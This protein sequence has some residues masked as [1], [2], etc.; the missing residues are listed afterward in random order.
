[1]RNTV[2]AGTVALI[3]GVVLTSATPGQAAGQTFAY[4]SL[5]NS[6]YGESGDFCLDP[7]AFFTSLELGVSGGLLG[8]SAQYING[9]WPWPNR[10]PPGSGALVRG[11]RFSGAGGVQES[12]L[13]RHGRAFQFMAQFNPARV[14]S[15]GVN[16]FV[17]PFV[18]VG[19]HISTDGDPAAAA[20]GQP[21]VYGIK[22]QTRP[23]VAYG[24]NGLLPLGARV[25][26]TAGYRG[27]SVFFGDFQYVTPQGTAVEPS[28]G[29]T[30]TSGIWTVGATIR[31]GS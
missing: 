31:V 26:L 28:P 20:N 29:Q 13:L 3:T 4:A 18:G 10:P 25:G 19:V 2:I 8:G 24:V 9:D 30:L 12:V 6:A 16:R 11:V 22:G 14:V 17:R 5:G 23:F 21:V 27:T 7:G 1:M 15:E